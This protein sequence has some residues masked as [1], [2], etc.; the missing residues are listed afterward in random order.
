MIETIVTS[1]Q[2]LNNRNQLI[3]QQTKEK[4]GE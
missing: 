2:F 1:P 4:K 3:S